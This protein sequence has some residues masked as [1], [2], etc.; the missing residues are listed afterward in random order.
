MYRRLGIRDPYFGRPPLSQP[1]IPL[2][3]MSLSSSEGSGSS[4]S[5]SEGSGSQG[6]ISVRSILPPSVSDRGSHGEIPGQP[7]GEAGE[8]PTEVV[9]SRSGGEVSVSGSVETELCCR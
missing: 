7:L 4:A 2:L 1:E 6:S 3:E 5:G 9:A 8:G